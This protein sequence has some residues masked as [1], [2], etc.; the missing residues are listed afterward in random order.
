MLTP[1]LGRALARTLL[2]AA[3]IGAPVV[4]VAGPA[5]A[6]TQVLTVATVVMPPPASVGLVRPAAI[7]SSAAAQLAAARRAWAARVARARAAHLALVLRRD[8][9]VV[10]WALARVGS[11][12]EAGGTGAGGFDCSGLTLAA[13]RTQGIAL[14]HYSVAQY[15]QYVAGGRPEPVRPRIQDRPRT[16]AA[17][18]RHR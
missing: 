14:P 1:W 10:H 7:P 18:R 12:Y 16:R 2:P 9:A 13:W 6:S 4:L 8:N 3:F 11:R 15:A 17:A 5:Q